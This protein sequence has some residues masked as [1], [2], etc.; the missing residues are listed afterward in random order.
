MA[1]VLSVNVG[2]PREVEWRGKAVRS[3]IWK[4]SVRGRVFAGRLN[5]AGDRQAD[6]DG[7]GGEQRAILVYQIESY[8]HWE[9]VLDSPAFPYG[10]FG[11]NLTVEGLADT[12]VCIGD[13]YRIGGAVFEVSQ[14]R[15]T[16]YKLGMHLDHP[17]MPG[18]LVAHHR[19]GFYFRVIEEGEIGAGD[20]IE[21]ICDGPERITVAQIDALLYMAPHPPD[22]LR[23]A[24]RIH[25]LSPGW[26][27]S[28][29]A[30]LHAAERGDGG[31]AGLAPT[32]VPKIFWAGFRALQV[33]AIN[34]ESDDVRSIE[35]ASPDGCQ[36]PEALPGQHLVVRIDTKSKLIT[37]NYSL[38]GGKKG[39]YRIAVKRELEGVASTYI[40]TQLK[41]GD[42]LQASA[43]RGTFLLAEGSLPIVLISAGIGA[44]PLLAMLRSLAVSSSER[45]V[46]WFH[47]ARDGAHHP[48]AE[49]VRILM[50]RLDNGRSCVAFSRAEVS[51]RLGIDYDID[52]R[53]DVDMLFN[54][55]AP[56]N[57]DFY[58]CGPSVFM[59]SISTGLKNVGVLATRIHSEAFGPVVAAVPGTDAVPPHR[60]SVEGSEPKVTF[61]RSGLVVGW[62]AS[63]GSLLELA[64]ACSVPVRWSCRS[65]VCHNCE[66]GLVEGELRYDPEPVDPPAEGLALICCS[67]PASDISLEL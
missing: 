67:T 33:A 58:L 3:G 11:E 55:G 53:L 35:F 62:D 13:R 64:E 9:A 21:K 32:L 63:Y 24:L 31:N 52:G 37:R 38:I 66:S 42:T 25:A 51:Q 23:R 10:R 30:L 22:M 48:F 7:H 28:M 59:A 18:L 60:P 4:T 29:R 17:Q 47:L 56:L 12:E 41:V 39:R 26:Q 44:T 8:R 43:P 36:L 45:C 27:G 61:T 5:L 40:H 34:Q 1:K 65:G 49:Q 50:A 15:V 57:A 20:H 2:L 6:L 46:F 14:P 19:P 16:C 54:H